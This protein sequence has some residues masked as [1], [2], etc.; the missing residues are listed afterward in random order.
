MS[1]I[2]VAHNGYNKSISNFI[3]CLN[4]QCKMKINYQYLGMLLSLCLFI[5]ACG[6]ADESANTAKEGNS[7]NTEA[8]VADQKGPEYTSAYICPMH[9]KGSGSDAEGKCPTC[10]MDYVANK[11]H[12]MHHDHDGHDHDGHDH[13]HD[14]DDHDHDGHDHDGHD[15]DS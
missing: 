8:S 14:G 12:E 10:K 3:N 7:D 5:A 4:N 15:H 6:N 9:C 11:D 2:K 1:I 13:D